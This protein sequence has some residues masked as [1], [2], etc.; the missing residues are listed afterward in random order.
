[1]QNENE[2]KGKVVR[3]LGVARMI[4]RKGGTD[5]EILDVKPDKFNKDRT[6]VV[7]RSDE[8]F[9]KVF[10]EVLDEIRSNRST[11][12]TKREEEINE[13]REEV[14]MLKRMMAEKE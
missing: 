4:K 6:V 12:N 11:I 13:L 7:F 14:E 9:E 1:M 8:K 3:N 10:S 2:V 5:V